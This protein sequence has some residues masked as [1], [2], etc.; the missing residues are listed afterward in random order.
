MIGRV[1]RSSPTVLPLALASAVVLQVAAS[2]V[3]LADPSWVPLGRLYN[4]GNGEHFYTANR[5]EGQR[6]IR[7]L[8]YTF[9]GVAG[10][11]AAAPD[12]ASGLVPLYRLYNPSSGDHFY[13]TSRPE[14]FNARDQLGY[15]YEGMIGYVPPAF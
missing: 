11:V 3:A 15:Q 12:P 9:E 6:A 14:G 2:G 13:T 10:Y 5:Q 4:P 7:Q 1:R 8:G